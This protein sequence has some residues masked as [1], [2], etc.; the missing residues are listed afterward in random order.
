MHWNIYTTD[1]KN[2]SLIQY[3]FSRWWSSLVSIDVSRLNHNCFHYIAQS[4]GQG[5]DFVHLL[6]L[7][8]CACNV[9]FISGFA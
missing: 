9:G 6:C 1:K 7:Y 8:C 2:P 5:G 3:K 4:N